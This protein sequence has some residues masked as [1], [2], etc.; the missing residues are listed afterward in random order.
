MTKRPDEMAG[1]TDLRGFGT[2]DWNLCFSLSEAGQ[3]FGETAEVFANLA[4][5]PELA[6]FEVG[7]VSHRAKLHACHGAG[8]LVRVI[9]KTS[10]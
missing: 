4:K 10:A 7:F 9:H 2:Q 1:E 3:I 8:Q 6:I 5:R